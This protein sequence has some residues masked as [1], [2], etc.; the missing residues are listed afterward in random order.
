ME[1]NINPDT[2]VPDQIDETTDEYEL[3]FLEATSGH[4]IS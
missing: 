4:H 2:G 1:G 3:L